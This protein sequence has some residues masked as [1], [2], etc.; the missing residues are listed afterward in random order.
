MRQNIFKEMLSVLETNDKTFSDVV[1]IG[2]PTHLLDTKEFEDLAKKSWYYTDK[3]AAQ[4]PTDLVIVGSDWW[5]QREIT[6]QN[7]RWVFCTQPKKPKA[8]L[9]LK[10]LVATECCDAEGYSKVSG[11]AKVCD[12]QTGE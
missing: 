5:L 1:W 11:F 9:G 8:N 12:L 10:C 2:T 4:M 6:F 7:E 3:D